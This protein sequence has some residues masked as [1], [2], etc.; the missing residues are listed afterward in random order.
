MNEKFRYLLLCSCFLGVMPSAE[1]TVVQEN[2]IAVDIQQK[3][4][5]VKGKITDTKGEPII[6]AT[7]RV[8]S[9][10]NAVISDVD[11]AFTINA[12]VNSILEVSYIGFP[13]KKIKV[14][15]KGIVTVVLQEDSK[16]L[17][18]V[19]VVGYGTTSIR[20][21]STSITAVD[22]KKI[23][24]V[25]FSDMGSTL[26][27]RVP[28]V[29]VQQGSAEPGQ[30]GASV[31]IR[32]NGEPLYVIDGFVSNSTRFNQLNKADIES[33]TVLKDAASTAVY[34]MNAGNGVIVITTKKGKSG[35]LNL[36][37]QSNFA[38]NTPS[39]MTD[40]LNAYEYATGVNNIR[41]SLGE[42]VNSFKT[43]A[44]MEEIKANVGSYTNWEKATMR[45]YTP[46]S[47]HT[48][49]MT[50]GSQ[51]I[52]IFGSLNYLT[53]KG[54]NRGDKQKYNRYN[55]RTNI[56]GTWD[57]VGVTASMGVNGTFTDENYPILSANTIYS[58][59]KDR[60]PFERPYNQDGTISNQFDNPVLIFKSPGVIVLKTVYNQLSG[61]VTWNIPKV[62]GLS[63]G[64]NGTYS[65]ENR[66]R[67]DWLEKS[68]YYDE[69]G[70]PTYQAPSDISLSRSSYSKHR[71]D[72]NLRVDYKNTICRHHNV[73]AT[74]VHN[75]QYYHYYGLSASANT[76]YVTALQLLQNGDSKSIS[77]S[78]G[79]SEQ[80]S[81]GFV[82][83]LHYDY[84][85]RYM[86]EFSGREDGSDCFPK[87]HRFGFFPSVSVGWAI[88]S[89]PFFK[90]IKD[91]KILDYLKFRASYG[92]IGV[93]GASHDAYAYMTTYNYNSNAY[94]IGGSLVNSITPGATP[95]INMTW[96]TR[97]KLDYGLDFITLNNRL[98]GSI[99]YFFERTKGYL[100][101]ASY[102]FVDPIGYTLPLVVS[103]AE[104]RSEGLDGSIKWKDH[105]GEFHY[106]AGFNFT[107][108]HSLAY[109]TNED[110][111][112]LSNPYTRTQGRY[113]G[114]LGT[115][116]VNT[117]FYNT[118]EQIL[119]NPKRT[120]SQD[121]R[122][123][124]L[125]YK[126]VNGDGKIDGQDQRVFGSN[127]SPR[128]VFG[129]DLGASWK[130]LS[131][132]ATIQGTGKRMSYMS[133]FSM[134]KEG[135]RRF[136]F[137]YQSDT[138]TP[139]N[140]KARFPRA[141]TLNLNNANNYAS[142]D[143]WA[144][145]TSY[146]RLKSLT[147]S[148]DLKQSILAKANWIKQLSVFASGVNLF[149]IGSS[150]KFADPEATTLDGYVYPMM[151]T[152]SVG[153]QLEF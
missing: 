114:Y 113:M 146:V 97:K 3:K 71:Y 29:I 12:P 77:A 8:Q 121:L 86:L 153:F 132:L 148:Y 20:K 37:Y 139:E 76:Y 144:V 59:I 145:N 68:T 127:S 6:G 122:P 34:G 48:L 73:E 152:Y 134:A 1:A 90:K 85:N 126:D 80:A 50:G 47:E 101:S 56:S 32:G 84:D 91:L 46:Q 62:K 94:V 7:V 88:S 53:Q 136:D 138:W 131:V 120:T 2:G 125:W 31:S 23:I 102:D 45:E 81:M 119:N 10:T 135:E 39:Y 24:K 52:K 105:V 150:T 44:E 4:V 57:K 35:Q 22:N 63:V 117:K 65:I 25:P 54:I 110:K 93:N 111:V 78:N 17:D 38:W 16:L 21:N 42:G 115:G 40:R 15:N 123:G 104:N 116:Y 36:N 82:G 106:N 75:R 143:F 130:G 133:L 9:T 28:G 61:N 51:N 64:F 14:A 149:A 96:Y 74:F 124:D 27:G 70:N 67:K 137:K 19:I 58:R 18:D 83:R 92:S 13:T 41:Q 69:D 60:T 151:R 87:G 100:S 5:T 98:E 30:N 140:T 118:P 95:S 79:E 107:W 108:Y 129:F 43:P 99:D 109:K 103:D 26:Q 142:S 33:I 112:A 141:G 55:Y 89:E 147:V 66:D 72:V 11:G 128:F 49:T